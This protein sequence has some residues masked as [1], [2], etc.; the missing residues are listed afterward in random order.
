LAL[1]CYNLLMQTILTIFGVIIFFGLAE[2]ILRQLHFQAEFIR[3]IGHFGVCVVVLFL[4]YVFS[5]RIIILLS[6]AFLGLLVL[7][8]YF[9]F[10][11][12]LG[13]H[14][15]DRKTFGEFYLPISV[16]IS[17]Y[18][19]LPVHLEAFQFGIMILGFSDTAAEVIGLLIGRHKIKYLGE[20]TWQGTTAFFL[21]TLLIFIFFVKGELWQGLVISI[22]LTATEAAL[23]FGLDNLVLPI[24]AGFLITLLI[25]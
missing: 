6:L 14:K 24:L 11:P 9:E 7:S 12:G 3:K 18:L 15:V 19:F 8:R 2:F 17:A 5:P 21:V 16:A 22:F 20:K 25:H 23:R 13:K 1:F 4:P 10:L